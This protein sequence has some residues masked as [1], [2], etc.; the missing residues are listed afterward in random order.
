MADLTTL[1]PNL[2]GIPHMNIPVG[3]KN[4]LPLGM[5]VLGDHFKEGKLIGCILFG[6]VSRARELKA[7]IKE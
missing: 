2:A 7:R 6:D 5:M 3:M 4:G 1:S